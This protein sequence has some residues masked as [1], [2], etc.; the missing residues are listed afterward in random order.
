MKHLA[1]VAP[2]LTPTWI[3]QFYTVDQKHHVARAIVVVIPENPRWFL[4]STNVDIRTYSTILHTTAV[5]T[6]VR[7]CVLHMKP[8]FLLVEL[9]T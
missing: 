1:L 8:F 4:L 2:I 3:Q 5:Y 9:R 7:V 6:V